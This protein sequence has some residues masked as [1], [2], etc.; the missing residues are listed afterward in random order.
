MPDYKQGAEDDSSGKIKLWIPFLLAAGLL[1]GILVFYFMQ[2]TPEGRWR[3]EGYS[4]N[5]LVLESQV[6][7]VSGAEGSFVGV[8]VTDNECIGA[9]DTTFTLLALDEGNYQCALKTQQPGAMELALILC[10][11][12]F[13]NDDE[14][15]IYSTQ[16]VDTLHLYRIKD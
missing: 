4:C 12:E 9:G 14:L 1:G 16:Y 7:A 3:A 11:M 5:G 10:S 8:Q 13:K 6:V 2:V 15:L